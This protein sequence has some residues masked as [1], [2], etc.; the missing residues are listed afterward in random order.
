MHV[1][2]ASVL[3]EPINLSENKKWE[4]GKTYT[5]NIIYTPKELRIT[6][7]SVK[8]WNDMSGGDITIKH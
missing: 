3:N 8:D 4:A 6:S 2:G 7:V 5:Y 1:N